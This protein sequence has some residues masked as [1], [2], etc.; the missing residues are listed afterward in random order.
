MADK[1]P[2]CFDVVSASVSMLGKENEL[3]LRI[4]A[5]RTLMHFINKMD[6]DKLDN[7]S[8]YITSILENVNDLISL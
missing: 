3:S 8:E 2:H 7:L 1:D 6:I 5:C 4:S